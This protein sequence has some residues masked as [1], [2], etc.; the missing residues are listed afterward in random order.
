M[1][2]PTMYNDDDYLVE[3]MGVGASG[4]VLK[5][6]PSAQLV[7]A[8][9]EI[10]RGGSYL[11]PRMLCQLVGDFHSRIKSANRAPG[12]TSLTKREREVLKMVAEGHSLKEIASDLNLSVKT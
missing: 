2:F 6:S 12:S 10:C 7:A 5:D 11:S 8:V 1:L 3:G 4:Y 9:R